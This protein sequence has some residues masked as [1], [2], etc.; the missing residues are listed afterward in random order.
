MHFQSDAE[1]MAPA[2]AI[3]ASTTGTDFTAKRLQNEPN[4]DHP[5]A[6]KHNLMTE[7][8]SKSSTQKW[9]RPVPFWPARHDC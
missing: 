7:K 5:N 1:I 6:H 9:H 2:G 8:T 4:G 3:L